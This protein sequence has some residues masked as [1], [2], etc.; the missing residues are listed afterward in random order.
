[1][2]VHS[3]EVDSGKRFEFG[4]NWQHF[5][6]TLT[7]ARL[8]VAEESVKNALGVDNLQGRTFLDIG[9]GSGLFSLSARRLGA[10]VVSFD[11][12]PQSVA[13]TR[14]LRERYFP[15]DPAWR[16]DEGSVLD[17]G[18]MA[19]HRGFDV[20]YSWGVL[21]HTGQMWEAI[22]NAVAK[23][24]SGGSFVI[25][26]Y[27]DQGPWS[28]RWKWLKRIYN[29]LPKALRLPYAFLVMGLRE[30]RPI[31]GSIIKLQPLK[32]IRGY[33]LYYQQRGMS[34][35]HDMVDWIGG[36]P[37]EVAKP[38]EVFDFFR[39]RGFEL[40]RMKT[41]AGGLGCNEFVF[42]RKSAPAIAGGSED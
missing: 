1:M 34:R 9:S 8:S 19:N 4:K 2:T 18:Y 27:N 23:V 31:I 36:Y 28:R 26:I 32:Y 35:W 42:R 39:V 12:D 20:V 5:L 13:C 6:E 24:N 38:E 16:I 15:N 7:P 33:T 29:A 25:S 41:C 30:L 40:L 11:F 37:F 10:E 21:H 17:Q 22:E 3:S 14:L